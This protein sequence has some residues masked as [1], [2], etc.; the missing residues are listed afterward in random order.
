MHHNISKKYKAVVF[1]RTLKFKQ[2]AGT[3]R[4]VYY[5]RTV[6]YVVITELFTTR[7]WGIGE[8][9]PLPGLSAD[10]MAHDA[11]YAKLRSFLDIFEFTGIVD[12]ERLR[13]YPSMLFGIETAWHSFTMAK[14]G[15]WGHYFDNEFSR[16]KQPIAINGLVWMGNFT[17]MQSRIE[18]KLSQGF[19]CI[20]LKIGAID[21][22]SELQLISDIRRRFS[23]D[24]LDIR[25]DANGAFQP[26][27]ALSRLDTLS[28]YDIHSIEQPIPSRHYNAM[29]ELCRKSPLPI[30]LDEELIGVN[31]L[32][33]KQ[34]L[35][36][37]IKPHYI[38]I[39]P[40]LHGGLS[41]AREWMDVAGELDI[42]YWTTS[43]LETNVGLKALAE[44]T[45][46]HTSSIIEHQGLGTG[47]L[48]IDNIAHAALSLEGEWLWAK[49]PQQREFEQQI[50]RLKAQ[51]NDVKPFIEVSSSGSTGVEKTLKIPK[52]ILKRSALRT[53]EHLNIKSKATA[54]IC[55]PTQY[56]AGCMMVVRCI[57]N[58][59]SPIVVAPSSRPFSSLQQSPYFAAV[60]PMQV[61]ESLKHPREARLMRGVRELIIGGGAISN[62][63]EEKLRKFPHHVWCTYGMAETA[64]NVALRRI[65]G[66]KCSMGYKPLKGVHITINDE[67][68]IEIEDTLLTIKHTTNDLAKFHDDG[69]FEIIGR[70]DN[71]ICSGGKKWLPE[72]IEQKLSTL[73]FPFLITAVPD[74]KYGEA[75]TLLH[76]SP[77]TETCIMQMCRDLVD[78][79]ECPK[80]IFRVENLPITPTGKPARKE[81]KKLAQNML[82]AMNS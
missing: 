35:L 76:T 20:K 40:S 36:H 2:P 30:A 25:V 8:C 45:F 80:R 28:R 18:T 34:Q 77:N 21:F 64:S 51:W 58:D 68:C 79:Q 69:G 75:I 54:L 70:K 38:V 44:W 27:E 13:P 17:E 12:T 47:Q 43:A 31:T 3:S 46:E 7:Y 78:G 52:E 66:D 15:R 1:K 29:A 63:I 67:G 73:P 37:G 71:V 16:G 62:E 14:N 59:L 42:P 74:E 57:V 23:R 5:D 65:N 26:H 19:R 41:G 55:L 49:T 53:I 10:D 48:F 32:Q 33:D 50:E 9:A 11:Y 22:E 61:Y 60:T 24:V 39:K 56:I 81:A 4:G 82:C 6:W 72:V